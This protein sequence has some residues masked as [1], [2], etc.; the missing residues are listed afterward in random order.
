MPRVFP[1]PCPAAYTRVRSRGRPSRRN[2]RSIAAV[3]A[4][5]WA[6]P[7][8]PLQATVWPS[9]IEGGGLLRRADPGARARAHTHQPPLAWMTWPVT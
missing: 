1:S 2:L 4:S 8:K 9:S 3:S 7:T 6:E 5:G